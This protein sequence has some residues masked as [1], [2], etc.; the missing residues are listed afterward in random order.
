MVRGEPV[1]IQHLSEYRYL[2]AITARASLVARGRDKSLVKDNIDQKTKPAI[3]DFA[4]VLKN[5]T[6]YRRHEYILESEVSVRPTHHHPVPVTPRST[7]QP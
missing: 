7:S 6:M 3:Q 1:M 2:G 4:P 5:T